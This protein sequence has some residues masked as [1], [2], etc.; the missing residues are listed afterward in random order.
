[1]ITEKNIK[2]IKFWIFISFLV[3]SFLLVLFV[4]ALNFNETA[5]GNFLSKGMIISPIL[6]TLLIVIT[7]STSLPSSIVA[8]AG[9]AL[10]PLY[11]LIPL[12]VI[13]M[14]AG[15][16]FMFYFAKQFGEEG[17]RSYSKIEGNK[18]KAFVKLLKLDSTSFVVLFTFFYFLPSNLASVAAALGDM[19]FKKFVLIT[20]VGNFLNLGGFIFLSYGVYSANL[21][22]I[23]PS[24]MV[25]VADSL[26]PLYIYRRN[27]ED[28]VLFIFN[29]KISFGRNK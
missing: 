7:S 25:L 26:I 20:L 14:F 11:L 21:Y 15:L 8:L 17:L 22:I 1:M 28:I 23:L 29:K 2:R 4:G 9:L 16:C 13:G 18:L 5:L 6:Y 10:F 3:L 19:K 27:I 12:T 24:A